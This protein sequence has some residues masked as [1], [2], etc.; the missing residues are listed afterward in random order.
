MKPIV[1]VGCGPGN[2]DY[3]TVAALNA[4][5]DAEVLVGAD[6]LLTLFPA[7]GSRRIEVTGSMTAVL[8]QLEP[9]L[10]QQVCVLVSGDSGLFSL[11]QLVI[12]RFGRE[13]CRV[14]PGISSVQVAF[15]R[16]ALSW[17]SALFISAHGRQP[18]ETTSDLLKYDRIALLAGDRNAI[19]WTAD[20][21]DELGVNYLVASC[22]N[23]TLDDETIRQ[24]DCGNDLRQTKFSSRTVL[25][26]LKRELLT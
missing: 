4:V 10:D 1:I 2:A 8:D 16:F 24:F 25:L 17:N 18:E 7:V 5:E 23:L 3:L 26:L 12:R 6:H 19:G 9:L 15:S 11:A 22:E 14:I 20:R 13:N 21:L